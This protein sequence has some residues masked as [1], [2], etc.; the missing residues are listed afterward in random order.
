MKLGEIYPL[1]VIGGII[2]LFSVVFIVFRPF[3]M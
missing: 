1:L 2:G 3:R